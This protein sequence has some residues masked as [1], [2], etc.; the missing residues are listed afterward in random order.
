ML[1]EIFFEGDR[2]LEI[3]KEKKWK[4]VLYFIRKGRGLRRRGVVS[5]RFKGKCF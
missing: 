2:K 5:W 3:C 4:E 1:G